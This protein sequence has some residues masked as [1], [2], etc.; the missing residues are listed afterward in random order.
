MVHTNKEMTTGRFF[1]LILLL[2]SY[3][4]LAQLG[5]DSAR[6]AYQD[7]LQRE[8]YDM[9][10][11]VITDSIYLENEQ[12]FSDYSISGIT[13]TSF[14]IK[15][16]KCSFQFPKKEYGWI[17]RSFRKGKKHGFWVFTLSN[18][19]LIE[20]WKKGTIESRRWIHKKE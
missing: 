2:L 19:I 1:S 3:T 15:T 4:G 8:T 5:A 9:V 7:Y 11:K 16:K 18:G 6:Q 14:I 12:N 17:M 13:D 20:R 10:M